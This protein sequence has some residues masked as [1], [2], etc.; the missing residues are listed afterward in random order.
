MCE[1]R[2]ITGTLGANPCEKQYHGVSNLIASSLA[3]QVQKCGTDLNMV[4]ATGCLT[5]QMPEDAEG[6]S[7]SLNCNHF[8]TF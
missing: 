1:S 3:I 2:L 6:I 8:S 5:L 7:S 4:M